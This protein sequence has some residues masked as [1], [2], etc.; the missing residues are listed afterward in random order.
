MSQ[1]LS[2]VVP[3]YNSEKYLRQ[4]IDSILNQTYLNVE[5]ILV[6]DGS[7]DESGR[8]CDSYAKQDKRVIVIHKE[9]EGPIKARFSGAEKASGEYIT[10]VD[11]DDWIEL[12]TYEQMMK[13][14]GNYDIVI[15]GIYRYY[16][17]GHIKVDRPMLKEGIYDKQALESSIIPYMLW[18]NKRN[19]WELDPSL[20]TKVFKKVLLMD[21][22]KSA[23]NLDM[24]FGDDT[25]VL[26]PFM[27][28][29]ESAV[30]I[31]QCFYYHRQRKKGTIPAYFSEE[32]FF[33]K[34]FFLYE[35]LKE[36]F[37]SSL[38]WDILQS[39]LEHF[40]INA[41]QLKQQSF[42]DYREIN[43]DVFPFWEIKKGSNIVL[44]GAGE[45]GRHFYEQNKQY[46]FC[47]IVLWADQNYERLQ[48]INDQISSPEQIMETSYDVIIIAVRS[49]GVVQEIIK[50]FRDMG[51]STKKVIWNDVF[52]RQI[53]MDEEKSL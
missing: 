11:G 48:L 18:S 35:F 10:F 43:I 41:V 12:D 47:N 50:R 45:S 30:I 17:E 52:V 27:L 8:I 14:T 49:A 33:T 37:E 39:Q 28:R 53:L 6:D 2:V 20:C 42:S 23:S 40:Y 15:A 31:N 38:Y 7:I 22:L 36:V 19:T 3:V 51:I 16:E 29:A 32:A 46:H 13:Y 26:F 1:K 44:Y 4:C 9:N 34:L 24:H 25:A 5:L 21:F